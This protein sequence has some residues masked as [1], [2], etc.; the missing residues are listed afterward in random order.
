MK[1]KSVEIAYDA[2]NK[3]KTGTLKVI[4]TSEDN[5]ISGIEFNLKGTSLTGKSVTKVDIDSEAIG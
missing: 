3:E 4:K 2:V 5:Y 1:E